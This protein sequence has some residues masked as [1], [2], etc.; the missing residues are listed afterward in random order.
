MNKNNCI[1]FI[2]HLHCFVSCATFKFLYDKI[3]L[4]LKWFY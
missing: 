4:F 3:Y 2:K 1:F